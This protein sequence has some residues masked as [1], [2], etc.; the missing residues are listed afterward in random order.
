VRASAAVTCNDRAAISTVSSKASRRIRPG[1]ERSKFGCKRSGLRITPMG[2]MNY[3]SGDWPKS[4][5][6]RADT[7]QKISTSAAWWSRGEAVYVIFE[8]IRCRTAEVIV[9]APS[10]E[11]ARSERQWVGRVRC[12]RAPYVCVTGNQACPLCVTGI[13]MDNRLLEAV[14]HQV[15]D[16]CF[17]S[18]DVP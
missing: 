10:Q 5:I 7:E 9:N 14:E 1:A 13:V 16:R 12:T 11:I 15:I 8:V 18:A 2:Q 6:M 4:R 3:G 17:Y